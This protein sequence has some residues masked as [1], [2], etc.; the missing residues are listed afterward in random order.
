[1]I[2][3]SISR[4]ERAD[5]FRLF[6]FMQKL[7][8]SRYIDMIVLNLDTEQDLTILPIREKLYNG[9]AGT[10]YA[11]F[12]DEQTKNVYTREVQSRVNLGDLLVISFDDLDFLYEN[13][14]FN[15]KLY[16]DDNGEVIYKD[17]IF[18][19]TQPKT[20]F[21]INDNQYISPDTDNNN[22]IVIQ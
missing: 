17:R 2:G 9:S 3:L 7:I 16:F 1:M 8:F 18:C 22:Y 6:F 11:K 12:T 19:T 14:F 21:S 13:A 15:I 20:S 10:L 4:S 5:L